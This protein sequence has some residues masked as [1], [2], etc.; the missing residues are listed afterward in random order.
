MRVLHTLLVLVICIALSI[1]ILL[2]IFVEMFPR[3]DCQSFFIII[4]G[5]RKI[6][7]RNLYSYTSI[8]YTQ[9]KIN[10]VIQL[11]SYWY[12]LVCDNPY[13]ALILVDVLC[14]FITACAHEQIENT[15]A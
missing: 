5:V 9:I 3:K 10:T 4:Q 12:R 6:T 1:I 11:S 8:L 14:S 15:I 13:T 7:N 2:I